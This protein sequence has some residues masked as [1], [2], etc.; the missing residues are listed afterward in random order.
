MKELYVIRQIYIHTRHSSALVLAQVA[1]GSHKHQYRVLVSALLGTICGS[2]VTCC[3][4]S[5]HHFL[6][7]RGINWSTS[8][9]TPE[10][11]GK[12]I[13]HRC[14]LALD[15]Y[16]CVNFSLSWKFKK[17]LN[18]RSSGCFVRGDPLAVSPARPDDGRI[19]AFE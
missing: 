10:I 12:T 9:V 2:Y 3:K 16:A 6:L 7:H 1:C 18:G 14:G 5:K 4:H 17:Y 13:E 8:A 15:L 11:P 19:S